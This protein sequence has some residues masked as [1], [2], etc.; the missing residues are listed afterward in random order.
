[1]YTFC[2]RGAKAGQGEVIIVG[3]IKTECKIETKIRTAEL[4]LYVYIA[5]KKKSL[6]GD[7]GSG[8]WRENTLFGGSRRERGGCCR[9]TGDAKA[10]RWRRGEVDGKEWDEGRRVWELAAAATEENGE[11]VRAPS[12]VYTPPFICRRRPTRSHTGLT[13][14]LY[15]P[16][17][18][19]HTPPVHPRLAIDFEGNW[20]R[21]LRTATTAAAAGPGSSSLR[22]RS[23]PSHHP[24]THL[25]GGCDCR[26][27]PS[28]PFKFVVRTPLM[29]QCRSFCFPFFFLDRGETTAVEHDK[30]RS[31]MHSHRAIIIRSRK[32][33]KV[34]NIPVTNGAVA[35]HKGCWQGILPKVEF[36]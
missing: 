29:T 12:A 6:R 1:M 33:W 27:Q 35:K 16:L 30:F 19:R 36:V 32:F 21:P 17:L 14:S 31:P 5:K 18:T 3:K 15:P 4:V 28:L 8:R 11:D 2:R 22:T 7:G 24:Y 25:S 23:R 10:G 13:V 9:T 26:Q 20:Y 34:V